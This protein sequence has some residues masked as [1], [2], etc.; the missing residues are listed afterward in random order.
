VVLEAA[1]RLPRWHYLADTTDEPRC[2]QEHRAR[3]VFH[4]AVGRSA[5]RIVLGGLFAA[6]WQLDGLLGATCCSPW[7]R[8]LAPGN[9]ALAW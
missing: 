5:A 3:R 2:R 7:S 1:S 8:S 4:P 9:L 6:F